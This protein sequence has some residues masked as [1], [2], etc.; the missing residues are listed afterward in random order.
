MDDLKEICNSWLLELYSSRQSWVDHHYQKFIDLKK[1]HGWDVV[2]K[3]INQYTNMELTKKAFLDDI[4]RSKKKLTKKGNFQEKPQINNKTLIPTPNEQSLKMVS[5]ESDSKYPKE[6]DDYP[7]LTLSSK[8]ALHKHN[9][10]V[11]NFE[12]IGISNVFDQNIANMKVKEY[13]KK[14]NEAIKAEELKKHQ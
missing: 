11:A 12:E 2:V 6:F 9:L 5:G 14:L 3:H 13:I 8:I 7:Q 10:G 4:Y 1:I